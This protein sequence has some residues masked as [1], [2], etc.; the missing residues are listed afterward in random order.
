MVGILFMNFGILLIVIQNIKEFVFQELK[1]FLLV[2]DIEEF[3]FQMDDS[4]CDGLDVL[5]LFK[6]NDKFFV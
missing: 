3:Y 1:V 6:V 5:L 2:E 4:F